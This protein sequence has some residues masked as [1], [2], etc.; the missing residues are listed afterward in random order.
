MVLIDRAQMGKCVMGV[1]AR[2]LRR[3]RS[4]VIVRPYLVASMPIVFLPA[5][6]IG[7]QIVRQGRCVMRS[8]KSVSTMWNAV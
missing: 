1:N 2:R 8:I 3:V 6:V 7:I 5:D 4:I